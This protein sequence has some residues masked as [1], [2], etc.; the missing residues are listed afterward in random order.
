MNTLF[1]YISLKLQRENK[2]KKPKQWF[3]LQQ[4]YFIK[5]TYKNSRKYYGLEAFNETVS[6]LFML[7]DVNADDDEDD[8][9]E[10]KGHQRRT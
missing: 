8:D 3:P 9:S 6:F 2:V 10:K 1:D 4:V 5:H 7:L